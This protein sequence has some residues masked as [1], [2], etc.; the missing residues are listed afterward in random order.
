MRTRL[1]LS[2]VLFS[3]IA[4]ACGAGADVPVGT[5]V[6]G[7]FTTTESGATVSPDFTLTLS[8]GGTWSLSEQKKPTII[9]FWADW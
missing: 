5:Q 9:L 7:Q 3:L 6:H 1:V 8:D 4:A 2:L